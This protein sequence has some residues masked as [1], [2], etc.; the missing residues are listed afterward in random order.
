METNTDIF[1]SKIHTVLSTSLS[2]GAVCLITSPAIKHITSCVEGRGNNV[3]RLLEMNPADK[4]HH[5]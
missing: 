3:N 2:V 4:K 5:T 1:E